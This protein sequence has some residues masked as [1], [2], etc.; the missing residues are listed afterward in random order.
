MKNDNW[1]DGLINSAS[2]LDLNKKDIIYR[3]LLD[4]HWGDHTF[5]SSISEAIHFLKQVQDDKFIEVKLMIKGLEACTKKISSQTFPTLP[6]NPTHPLTRSFQWILGLPKVPK[7]FFDPSKVWDEAIRLADPSR[8]F[9]EF[10]VW[11]GKSFKYFMD[12]GKFK[13]G[14]GF[15]TFTGLPE[16][17]HHLQP[18]GALSAQGKMPIVAG[19]EFIKGEFKDTLPK[20]FSTERPMASLINFD[21]DLYS[22]TSCALTHCR[23]VI[24]EKTILLFDE[25]L[26]ITNRDWELDEYKAFMEF[27]KKFNLT[28]EV[29]AVSFCTLQV[30]IKVRQ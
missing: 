19:A 12:K 4:I 6:E 27:C 20:F 15:D 8:S 13:K 7:I 1:I 11:K 26:E 10:G 25:F 9:Y 28:Y 30:I 18:K 2:S 29:L 23:D 14:F 21:A 22:S 24:D 5:A 16:R 3:P 17:W